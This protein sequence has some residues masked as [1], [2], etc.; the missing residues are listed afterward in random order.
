MHAFWRP[1]SAQVKEKEALSR[2]DAGQIRELGTDPRT[3]RQVSARMGRFGPCVQI[4]TREDEEKPRFARLRGNQSINTISLEEALELFKLPRDLGETSDGLRISANVGRFGPYVRYGGNFVSLQEGDDP[5]TIDLARAL[6]L[7]DAKQR[8]DA[9]KQ[10]RQFR[11]EDIKVLNGRY[12]PYVT[13][14]K[15]NVR[16]P[17]G[18]DPV[19]LSLDEAKALLERAPAS[20][21]GPKTRKSA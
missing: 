5:Y 9:S 2:R 1:F 3:G 13:D 7:I 8:A 4:G 6:A 21:R 17:K 19:T 18:R 11:D 20:R 14:G 15:K 12:G 10:I 16:V